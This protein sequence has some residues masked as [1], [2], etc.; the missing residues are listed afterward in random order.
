MKMNSKV[1]VRTSAAA[2]AVAVSFGGF[3]LQP[4]IQAAA[5]AVSSTAPVSLNYLSDPVRTDLMNL[6]D[7]RQETLKITESY[8]YDNNPNA[9]KYYDLLKIQDKAY[10]ITMDPAATQ[11]E[12]SALKRE[13]EQKLN[14]YIDQFIYDSEVAK[15]LATLNYMLSLNES[16]LNPY[17]RA[18]LNAVR[19]SLAFVTQIGWQ[20]KGNYMRTFKEVYL[21]RAAKASELYSYNPS[22]YQ[23][24][25]SE[26]RADIKNRLDALGGGSAA[27]T[28]S[29]NAFNQ[30]ASLL[31]QM[32]ASG[33]NY[34]QV[35][36]AAG[37]LEVRYTT[38]KAELKSG[39]PLPEDARQPLQTQINYA[40]KLMEQPKGIR[41]GQT[42]Q[43]A[44]G[45]LRRAIRKAEAVLKKATT[46]EE[47]T[48]AHEEL[49]KAISVFNGRKKP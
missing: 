48:R 26:Y 49:T 19:D 10:K 6:N 8:N 20:E 5:P 12:L 43:S 39:T 2:L 11:A 36:M 9:Y 27:Y 44:F 14:D 46:R 7:M 31:D 42:P 38:L 22:T 13:Y 21:P 17:E 16:N 28:A 35:R 18:K 33:S 29:I 45:D 3:G 24:R 1:F 30:A 47:L 37:N 32:V 15:L 34:N 40:W 4:S 25:I 23:Q 41:S